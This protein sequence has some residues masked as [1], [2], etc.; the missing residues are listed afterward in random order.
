[1]IPARCVECK[2]LIATNEEIKIVGTE[3][4]L[5]KPEGHAF[6]HVVCPNLE[7]RARRLYEARQTVGAQ[8]VE[9]RPNEQYK[10]MAPWD[11]AAPNVKGFWRAIIVEFDRG[12]S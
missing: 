8:Q 7:A 2:V 1:M 9:G 3:I 5:G 10:P 12:A 6:R 11:G 4:R